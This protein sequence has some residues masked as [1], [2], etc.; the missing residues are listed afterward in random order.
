MSRLRYLHALA[1]KAKP[2]RASRACTG[3]PFPARQRG[4]V[5][6]I[7]LI[8]LVALTLGGIAMIRQISTGILVASNLSFK[9]SA[10]VA[11][12]RGVEAARAWLATK[13][14]AEL[15]AGSLTDGYFAAWCN[16][17]L[18]AS[19]RPDADANGITDDCRP[20]S[21]VPPQFVPANYNWT[22]ANAKHVTPDDDNGNVTHY[23]VHRLCRIPGGLSST[24]SDGVPQDCVTASAKSDVSSK[25]VASYGVTSLST[26]IKPYYRITVRTRGPK[27]TIAYS[28]AIIH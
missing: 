3:L 22:D 8:L 4:V 17:M 7:S 28:Q 21:G 23:V 9:N 13:S 2:H 5:L 15:E 26:K 25:G 11:S 1:P 27:D 24:N 12:D 16:S 14:Q 6:L 20:A 10:L 19:G 18:D